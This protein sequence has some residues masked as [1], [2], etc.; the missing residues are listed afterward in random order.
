MEVT[1]TIPR[2]VVVV[3]TGHQMAQKAD[4]LQNTLSM[5][6]VRL[7]HLVLFRRESLRLVELIGP[8]ADFANVMH[9]L[10]VLNAIHIHGRQVH[11]LSIIF[12]YMATRS[13][14]PWV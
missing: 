7:N 3:H 4:G 14:W 13:E 12:E 9:Q 6:R 2:F 10:A 5:N 1:R 8:N 11:G